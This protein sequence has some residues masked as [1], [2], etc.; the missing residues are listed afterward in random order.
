[1]NRNEQPDYCKKCELD[2][3]GRVWDSKRGLWY[4]TSWTCFIPDNRERVEFT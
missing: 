3:E 1:M 2:C 4:C